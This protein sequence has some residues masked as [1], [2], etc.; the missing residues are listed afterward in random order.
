MARTVSILCLL[1]QLPLAALAAS[2]TLP[3]PIY[4]E[5]FNSA[6]E[7]GLPAGW[8]RTNYSNVP[9]TTSNLVDLDSAPYAGW[10][11]LDRNR[12]TSNFLSYT[13]HTPVDYSR[14]LSFNSA[15]VVNGQI[16]T[17]LAAGRFVFCTS[18]YREG[19]QVQYLFSPDYN[20]IGRTNIYVSYHSLW[21]Q[22]QDNLGAVEYS[23]DGGAN[24]LPVVYMLDGPDVV[25]AT[26]VDAVRTFT[27]TYPDVATYVDPGTGTTKGGF[28]GAFIAT[29]ITQA[30]APYISARVNDD[31][32]ESKR[33][34]LFRLVAA[35]NKPAVRFRF[36]H[37]GTDSWY[38][39]IDDFGLYSIT[40]GT[41]PVI[42]AA[43]ADLNV[44][45]GASAT[46]TVSAT[47]QAPLS[48][49]WRLNGTNIPGATNATLILSSVTGTNQGV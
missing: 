21:E 2:I 36:A 37:A 27:N 45:V 17:N 43:P 10:L 49:Q 24:W 40:P 9:L 39:G 13:S 5:D 44:S 46:F 6:P 29:P 35:D 20:L 28:Y 4:L 3:T 18:G 26:G 25:T 42:T 48:Y 16:V 47:G 34:E 8:S 31:P 11:V 19:S 22:N 12:F 15:N 23:V 1:M 41:T 33:V 14:V 32:V 30:L 7:G 38:F